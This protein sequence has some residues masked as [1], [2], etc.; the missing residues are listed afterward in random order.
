MEENEDNLTTD[1]CPTPPRE[2]TP[3]TILKNEQGTDKP[4]P[5]KIPVHQGNYSFCSVTAHFYKIIYSSRKR[6]KH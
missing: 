1:A 6:D 2:D 4:N 5:T 3:E